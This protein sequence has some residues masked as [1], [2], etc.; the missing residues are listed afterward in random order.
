[1]GDKKVNKLLDKLKL[2]DFK[3][4]SL[5]DVTTAINENYSTSKLLQIYEFILR[6]QLGITKLALFSKGSEWECL[7]KYNVKKASVL[8]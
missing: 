3:L 8:M 5:L 1:M 6:D 7:L 2:K 4:N